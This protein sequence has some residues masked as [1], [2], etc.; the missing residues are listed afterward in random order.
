MWARR[1]PR[2]GTLPHKRVA[3]T[4]ELGAHTARRTQRTMRMKNMAW[5]D[6][7]T[8]DNLCSMALRNPLIVGYHQE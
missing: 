8:T 2:E 7:V 5:V 4:E 6:G 3:K 1:T